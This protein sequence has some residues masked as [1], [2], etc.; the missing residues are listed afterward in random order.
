VVARSRSRPAPP[1]SSQREVVRLFLLDHRVCGHSYEVTK[2]EGGESGTEQAL[3]PTRS[4][5]SPPGARTR[6]LGERPCL[7]LMPPPH[8]STSSGVSSVGTVTVFVREGAA[9]GAY[10]I[11][12]I[13]DRTGAPAAGIGAKALGVLAEREEEEE[14]EEEEAAGG[15]QATAGWRL[16]PPPASSSSADLGVDRLSGRLL[17]LLLPPRP[18]SRSAAASS[19]RSTRLGKSGVSC[20]PPAPSRCC[21]GVPYAGA[22]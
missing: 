7:H 15:G 3:T 11:A 19:L 22:S 12:A 13:G 21:W 5:P 20:S 8:A 4:L 16:R 17:L 18:A 1:P 10:S 6:W 2:G 14:E 9:E